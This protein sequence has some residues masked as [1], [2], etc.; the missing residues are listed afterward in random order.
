[1]PGDAC[2]HIAEKKILLAR[3]ALFIERRV[4]VVAGGVG[5]VVRA[6][7]VGAV[8]PAEAG[9]AM[10]HVHADGIALAQHPLQFLG[11]AFAAHFVMLL[12]PVIEPAGPVFARHVRTVGTQRVERGKAVLCLARAE[13]DHRRQFRKRAIRNLFGTIGGVKQVGCHAGLLQQAL[14]RLHVRVIVAERS[15]FV[16]HLHG[17]NRAAIL[18]QQRT[19]LFGEAREPALDGRGV[20]RFIAAQDD[21]AVL[22]Q[23]RWIAA[24]FPLRADV[25]AGAKNHVQ[26]LLLRFAN[27]LRDIVLPCEVVDARP[28]LMEVPEDVGRDGVEPHGASLA[29]PV[30][31][32]GTRHARV[33]HLAGDDLIRLTI[34]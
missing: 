7:A 16:F 19:D 23:P 21:A 29:K 8:H 22:Q 24:K 33:M 17:D 14:E 26:A 28:R 11:F 18:Q 30:A 20:F 13:V 31:P 10:K 15:V 1:M 25:W 27:V 32:I 5:L 12:A 6:I 34:E 4:V 3:R 9:A 2:N